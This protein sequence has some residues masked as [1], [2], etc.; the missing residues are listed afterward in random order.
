MEEI[1]VKKQKYQIEESLNSF[2]L[3][4]SQEG[5]T[6]IVYDFSSNPTAFGDFKFAMKRLKSSGINIPNV[7]VIDKKLCRAVVEYI[8]GPT[9]LD[10]LNEKDIEDN[11]FEQLFLMNYKARINSMRLDFTPNKFRLMNG[12]LYYLPFT[13]TNYVRDEDFT[14]KE[15]KLWFYFK[16]TTSLLL[17]H[18]FSIDKSRI[19][20]EYEGN[21]KMVLIVVK[22]FH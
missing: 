21:K 19:P 13:F 8:D 3:K 9:G 20:T 7:L 17:E 1:I 6:Y 11:I 2:I 22:Y 4:V 10:L 15:L 12:K 18:G 14:Q 5:K 16:E